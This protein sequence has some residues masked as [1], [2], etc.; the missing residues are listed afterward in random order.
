MDIR[1][2]HVLLKPFGCIVDDV[3]DIFACTSQQES[4]YD[5]RP[6]RKLHALGYSY[7]HVARHLWS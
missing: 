6:L 3:I 5:K 7:G 4:Y 1:T 2:S